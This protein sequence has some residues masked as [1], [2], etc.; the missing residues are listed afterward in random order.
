MLL[1]TGRRAG[2]G[3]LQPWYRE[4][5]A[6]DITTYAATA[7]DRTP[8]RRAPPSAPTTPSPPPYATSTP[9]EAVVMPHPDAHPPP[10]RRDPPRP[11]GSAEQPAPPTG[12]AQIDPR[13]LAEL[14]ARLTALEAWRAHQSDLLD[15]LLNPTDPAAA[16]DRRWRTAAG[17]R[18]PHGTAVPAGLGPGPTLLPSTGRST[19]TP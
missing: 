13:L 5:D 19:A 17:R 8:P 14:Q 3:E 12:L 18:R 11:D 10:A 15:E 7:L 2:L 1:A 4:P 16:E 9:E 6:T